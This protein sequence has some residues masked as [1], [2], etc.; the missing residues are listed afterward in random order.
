[1]AWYDF[2]S[3][4][5][6]WGEGLGD[7]FGA[8]GGAGAAAGGAA[9]AGAAA[10]VTQ[11]ATPSIYEMI[12]PFL[13]PALI[14]G[15]QIYG[16]KSQSDMMKD[17]SAAQAQSYNQYLNQLN[18]PED[19]KQAQFR[20]LESQVVK[21]V[22]IMRRRLSNELASRG[23]RGQGLASPTAA[24]EQQMQDLRNQAY[25]NV[26]GKY[27]VPQ[28]PPPVSYAPGTGSLLGSNVANLGTL[29]AMKNIFG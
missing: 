16:A 21:N 18:P 17:L 12:K 13:G 22:P 7:I 6:S 19:V 29:L 27:N 10:G 20:E 28:T 25:F 23:V 14:A 1:M 5:G 15:S 8:G 3:D 2:L 11:L 26:Y 4:W 24:S 9:G